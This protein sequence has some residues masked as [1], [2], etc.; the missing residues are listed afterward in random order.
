MIFQ[1]Q[2]GRQVNYLHAFIQ[3]ALSL[4]EK[5]STVVA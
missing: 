5:L 4:N 1:L 3:R 2:L